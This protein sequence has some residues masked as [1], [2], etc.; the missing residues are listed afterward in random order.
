VPPAGSAF[1]PL[2]GLAIISFGLAG[3]GVAGV[4]GLRA[5]LG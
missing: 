4:R 1:D 5:R 2:G 3:V